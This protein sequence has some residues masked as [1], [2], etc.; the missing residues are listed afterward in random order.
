MSERGERIAD[1]ARRYVGCSLNHRVM[2][3]AT[4]VAASHL[5]NPYE[6]VELRTNCATFTRGVMDSCGVVHDRL[7]RPYEVGKAVSDVLAIADRHGARD[8]FR[9]QP[10]KR[11][12]ILHY[13]TPGETNDHVECCLLEEAGPDVG[14]NKLHC[15]GGRKDNAITEQRSDIRWSSGRMLCHVI[16]PDLLLE[17]V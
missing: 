10:L 14:W 16:D 4:L 5:D 1:T 11:G 13:V 7:G 12:T 15:G 8:R 6:V 2:E 17:P 9:G 3:L